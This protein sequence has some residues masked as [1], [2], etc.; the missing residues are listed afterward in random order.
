[1]RDV[2]RGIS[3]VALLKGYLRQR[4]LSTSAFSHGRRQK[5]RQQAIARARGRPRRVLLSAAVLGHLA[6][7]TRVS[8]ACLL[9]HSYPLTRRRRERTSRWPTRAAT[10]QSL[11]PVSRASRA[12]PTVLRT[13]L[14][15]RSSSPSPPSAASGPTSTPPRVSSSTPCSTASTPPFTGSMRS[16]TAMRSS[17]RFAECGQSTSSTSARASIRR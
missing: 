9:P 12:P 1:M 4:S 14:R 7:Q 15:S 2:T 3:R 11:A 10:S 13:A 5:I 17:A 6:V 16:R 8:A